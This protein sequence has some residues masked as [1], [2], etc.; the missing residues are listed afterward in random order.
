MAN[1]TQLHTKDVMGQRESYVTEIPPTLWITQT[2]PRKRTLGVQTLDNCQQCITQ[3]RQGSATVTTLIY[4]TQAPK[5]YKPMGRTCQKNG[6]MYTLCTQGEKV[7]CYKPETPEKLNVTLYT[8]FGQLYSGKVEGRHAYVNH[9]TALRQGGE[10]IILEFDAC[11]AIDKPGRTGR[12][13][14]GSDSWKNTYKHNHKYLC[15]TDTT[16][17]TA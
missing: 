6:T 3:A 14:C 7:V 1:D 10:K 13:G 17:I 15:G 8:G 4:H 16:W 5:G 11:T 2:P 12:V 9:T